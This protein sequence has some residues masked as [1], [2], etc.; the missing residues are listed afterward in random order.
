MEKVSLAYSLETLLVSRAG[1]D[2]Y[3]LVELTSETGVPEGLRW[4]RK[5]R[6]VGFCLYSD[7]FPGRLLESSLSRW[8][9][10]E[11]GVYMFSEWSGVLVSGSDF[12]PSSY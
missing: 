1:P 2:S 9:S 4:T 10:Q 11:S 6:T 5:D 8:F 7:G 3:S 12:V